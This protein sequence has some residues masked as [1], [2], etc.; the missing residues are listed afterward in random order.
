LKNHINNRAVA[1][2]QAAEG[3]EDINSKKIMEKLIE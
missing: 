1:I 3:F 2:L